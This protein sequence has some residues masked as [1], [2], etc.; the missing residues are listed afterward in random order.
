MTPAGIEPPTF[1]F[2][3]QHLKH[4][5]TAVP[6]LIAILVLLLVVKDKAVPVLAWTGPEGSR[7]L[8]FPVFK[9]FGT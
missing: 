6:Y 8:M 2:V 5:A 1:R 7:S 4:C 3:S 9:T